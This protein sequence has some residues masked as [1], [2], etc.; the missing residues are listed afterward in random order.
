MIDLDWNFKDRDAY[1]LPQVMV[2]K[3]RRSVAPI[4]IYRHV[5]NWLVGKMEA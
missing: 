5:G 2:V 4:I 3:D 1:C